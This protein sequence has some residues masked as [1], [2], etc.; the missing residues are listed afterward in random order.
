[1]RVK[2]GTSRR[3]YVAV[4]FALVVPDANDNQFSE[5]HRVEGPDRQIYLVR[6]APKGITRYAFGNPS[7]LWVGVRW[8]LRRRKRWA[9]EVYTVGPVAV[10]EPP[11]LT[12]TFEDRD[13]AR[14][15]ASKLV[16]QLGAGEIG[17]DRWHIAK[18]PPIQSPTP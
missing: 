3:R 18:T 12:E 13:A 7:A 17:W 5:E 16:D 11:V 14:R 2:V 4:M 8:H 1:M 15:R 10:E 6:V 9:T